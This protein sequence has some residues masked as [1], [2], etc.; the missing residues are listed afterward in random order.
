MKKEPAD[1]DDVKRRISEQYIEEGDCW[2]WTGHA[3][4]GSIPMVRYKST[5]GKW[6]STS[7]RKLSAMLA[8]RTV[9]DGKVC[10]P[11][12]GE[13]LCINPEH[14]KILSNRDHL[15]RVSELGVS[16]VANIRR[17]AKISETRRAKHAKLTQEDVRQ[18][19]DS[20]LTQRELSRLY[21]ICQNRISMIKQGKAW[22]SHTATPFSGLTRT[23]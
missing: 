20:N 8:G 22:K 12:C 17:A 3:A 9:H 5:E 16:G 18:I 7:A 13:P 1:W 4:K 10:I 11:S 23:A 21:G 19:R 14:T 15:T 2:I 6:V